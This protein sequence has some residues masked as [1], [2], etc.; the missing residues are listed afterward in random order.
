MRTTYLHAINL[1]MILG[2]GERDLK[3][4]PCEIYMVSRD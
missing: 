1:N 4:N 2:S 3:P